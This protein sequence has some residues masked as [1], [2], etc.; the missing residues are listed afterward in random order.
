MKD[1]F[2]NHALAQAI[3]ALGSVTEAEIQ[4]LPILD[5]TIILKALPNMAGLARTRSRINERIRKNVSR[6][7][8]E[9]GDMCEVFSALTALWQYDPRCVTANQLAVAI[10]RMLESEIEIGGPYSSGGTVTAHANAQINLLMQ[11][12]AKPLPKIDAY[13]NKVILEKQFKDTEFTDVTLLY[14][15]SKVSTNSRLSL[16]VADTWQTTTWQ[17][18]GRTAIALDILADDIETPETN[19]A[20]VM[21]GRT[22]QPNGFWIGEPIL[23][24]ASALANSHLLITALVVE[25]LANHVPKSVEPPVEGL[26]PRHNAIVKIAKETFYTCNEPLRST[27]LTVVDHMRAADK[28]FEIM[29]LPH[30][31]AL[32]LD[33]PT[34]LTDQQDIL[35]CLANLYCW[36]A[37][38]IY[39]DFL[40]N[41]GTPWQLPIANI[42][43]RACLKSYRMTLLNQEDFLHYT[44][45]V[46]AAMDEANAWEVSHCRFIVKDRKLTI[47]EL[48][49]YGTLSVLA[50]RAFAHALGPMAI[51][52][53]SPVSSRQTQHVKSAF[54][55][56][57]IARQLNDDMQD[58]QQDVQTGQ[59]SY[60]VTTILRDMRMKPG[61][62][63]FAHLLPAMQKRFRQT[64]MLKITRRMLSH[65]DLSRQAFARS[66]TLRDK[67]DIYDLLNTLERSAEHSLDKHSKGHALSAR[68]AESFS[69]T[70]E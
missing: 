29:L 44:D 3:A 39:D 16:Y 35:L 28:N 6:A 68:L 1:D 18:P 24:A 5:S 46:F 58:W 56:Y 69:R 9:T 42:S 31:F 63:D 14:F 19:R 23:K 60:V 37:Y 20:L 41:E 22:Q 27:A 52:A 7:W 65:I 15:L 51:L 2:I 32:G 61:T 70:K 48:P 57:L 40:D 4:E 26:E 10:R 21:L 25:T 53:E 38:T 34:P 50:T 12:V 30:F 11:L 66:Q 47:S 13:L 36:I 54:R 55:H 67:N 59:A 8:I 49:K 64:T 43:L 17:T 33:V 62:Y 45:R